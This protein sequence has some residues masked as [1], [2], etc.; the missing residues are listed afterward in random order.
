MGRDKAPGPDG[1]PLEFFTKNWNVVGEHVTRTVLD[2]FESGRLLKEV[3]NTILALVLKCANPST[4]SDYRP[5][6]CCNVLYKCI[7]KVMS[8]R[9]AVVLPGLVGQEQTAFVASRQIADN[10]LLA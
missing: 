10:I 5:I 2:F 6:S 1:F 7:T 3:S 4:L 9:L 8:R